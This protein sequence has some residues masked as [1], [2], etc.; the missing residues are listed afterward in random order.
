MTHV[1]TAEGCYVLISLRAVWKQAAGKQ[2]KAK[3]PAKETIAIIWVEVTNGLDR[4]GS[5]ASVGRWLVSGY[6]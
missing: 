6:I 3:S 2:D 1:L 4:S 5:R